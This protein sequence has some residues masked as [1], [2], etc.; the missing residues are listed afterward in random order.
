[1]IISMQNGK[2]LGVDGLPCEFY[3]ITWGIIGVDF[4]DLSSNHLPWGI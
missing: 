1:M 3:K 4:S 2:Y